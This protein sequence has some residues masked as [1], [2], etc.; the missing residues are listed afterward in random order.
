MLSEREQRALRQIEQQ[1]VADDPQFVAT[2]RN[3]RVRRT[4][5]WSIRRSHDV[6]VVI[7]GLS[8]LLC[9]ALSLAGPAAVAILLA[10]VTFA[11]RPRAVPRAVD[12]RQLRRRPAGS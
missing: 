11:L 8:A 5:R 9:M 7:S 6:I 12:L 2:M 3:L 1:I 10:V 4:G